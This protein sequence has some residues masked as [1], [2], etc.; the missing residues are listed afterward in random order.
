M[1]ALVSGTAGGLLARSVSGASWPLTVVAGAGCALAALLLV[2]RGQHR[3]TRRLGLPDRSALVDLGRAV[4]EGR[5]PEDPVLVEA[6]R[7]VVRADRAQ[8]RRAWWVWPVLGASALWSAASLWQR[9][10]PVVGVVALVFLLCW[11]PLLVVLDRRERDR[12]RRL[13]SRLER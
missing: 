12:L 4:K 7:R 10:G 2:R 5:I 3:R 6:L 8:R 13:E 9:H 11:F 1:P